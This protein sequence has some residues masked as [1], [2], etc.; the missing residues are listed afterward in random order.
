MER[1]CHHLQ[2]RPDLRG[3]QWRKSRGCESGEGAQ[4]CIPASPWLHRPAKPRFRRRISEYHD[5]GHGSLNLEFSP[6]N[7]HGLLLAT[8]TAVFCVV[9]ARADFPALDKL[10]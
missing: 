10:P 7:L 9:A 6:M 2:G 4:N 5:Q 8:V 1:L 3:L